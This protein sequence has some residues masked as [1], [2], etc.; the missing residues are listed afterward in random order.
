MTNDGKVHGLNTEWEAPDWPFLTI[1]EVDAVLRLFPQARRA[2]RI[3]TYS[4]R[5]FSAASLVETPTGMVFVKR[6]HHTVRNREALLEEHRFLQHLRR[7]AAPVP[8]VFLDEEGASVVQ[9][10][11][12]TYEVHAPAE[13]IDLY[14][15][16]LSWTPFRNAQ[17]A[18]AAGITLAR[19]HE[20]SRS[21]N[22]P[23]RSVPTLS[24]GFRIFSQPEPWPSLQEYVNARPALAAY[25]DRLHWKEEVEHVLMPFH[26]R[27][28][29]HLSSLNPL[30]THNDFHASNLFWSSDPD[31]A[32]VRSIIDF[33]L[34]DRTTAMYDLVIAI[35]R[36]A[37]RWLALQGDFDEVV[38]L[39]QIDALLR[40]YQSVRDLSSEESDALVALL[41]LAHAEFALSETDYFLRILHSES[42]AD[43]GWKGY[44]LGHAQ[45]FNRDHGQR[46]LDHLQSW[47]STRY[48]GS[49]SGMRYVGD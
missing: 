38:H 45:W 43:L 26:A 14:Q 30:W 39:D 3:L 31:T 25:L 5:P 24:G 35:E 28:S 12:W 10:G 1:D 36:N 17:H 7:E 2:I 42:K 27:L 47:A 37:I 8:E 23:A 34:C 32:S 19:L 15:Q 41:P 6:H 13:G 21:F 18:R 22:A 44:C 16:E 48:R 46:L 33:G 20:A 49:D 29:P 9:F 11:E 40:G 4:A